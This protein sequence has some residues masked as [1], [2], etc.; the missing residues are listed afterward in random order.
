MLDQLR[1]YGDV[2]RIGTQDE[3][4]NP[5]CEAQHR[6]RRK[7]RL[8]RVKH[9]LLFIFPSEV[10]LV[11]DTIQRRRY[12]GVVLDK[13]PMIVRQTVKPFNILG[14]P[15]DRPA[16]DNRYVGVGHGDLVAAQPALQEI[17]LLLEEDALLGLQLQS[18]PPEP[19]KCFPYFRQ[20][21][22]KGA[23]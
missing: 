19:G 23:S 17:H 11:R 15:G 14:A 13:N 9:F 20:M 22:G 5:V 7:S 16:F 18:V 6:G 12:V 21:V 2:R 8:Q 10:V 3:V 1:S 4:I